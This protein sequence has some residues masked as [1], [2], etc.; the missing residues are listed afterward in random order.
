MAKIIPIHKK[1]GQLF[2]DSTENLI[3]LLN[4]LPVGVSYFDK[5]QRYQFNNKKYEEWI[6]I[7]LNEIQGKYIRDVLGEKTYES[8]RGHIEKA[9]SGEETIYDAEL[10]KKDGTTRFFQVNLIPHVDNSGN[11]EGCY[12]HVRDISESVQI[13][14]ERKE[15]KLFEEL[16]S[17]LSA[18]FIKLPANRIDQAINDALEE[19]G[20]F[21]HLDRSSLGNLTPDGREMVV[22][23]VWNRGTVPGVLKS[24]NIERHPW[25]LSPFLTGKD[26]VWSITEGLPKG[27]KEDVRLLEESGMQSFAGIPVKI[28][29]KLKACLGFSKTSE[30]VPFTHGIIERF[31][32]LAT[33]FGNVLARQNAVIKVEEI[34]ERLQTF[35][36]NSPVFMYLKD[37][38]GKHLFANQS[39]LKYF[40][41][42]LDEFIGTTAYDYLPDEVA[43][44]VEEQDRKVIEK[45]CSLEMDDYHVKFEAKVL[46]VK[47]IKFPIKLFEGESGV[48]GIVMDITSLKQKEEDLQ[49]AYDEIK[50]LKER[51]EVENIYLRDQI[52]VQSTHQD[53]IGKS[54][55]MQYVLY[56]IKQVAPSDTTVLILGETGTGKELVAEA[57]HTESSR[58][59]RH[60]VKVNCAALP[61]NL[62]ESELFGREKGA[63]TGSMAKQIGR[64]ELADKRTLFLDEIGELPL[65]LQAKLLRVIQSG[66]FERLGSPHTIR[67]D[68]RIIASTNRDLIDEVKNGRFREDLYYR[69]N[70]FPITVPPLHKRKEDIPMIVKYFLKKFGKKIG[71]QIERVP[72]DV[73]KSLQ[74]YHWPGNVRELE[75]IIER[76][77]IISPDSTLHL[78]DKLDISMTTNNETSQSKSLS[79]MERNHISRILDQTRWKI[80]GRNGA[81]EI[82]NLNPSTLRSRIRKLGI[83]KS[84]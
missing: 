39:L 80:E 69:L 45:G 64:F 79:D 31:H 84:V 24:Y 83:I 47:E 6:G 67:V 54:D 61:A 65:E 58:R 74:E 59:N 62:I 23:H 44:N 10:I 11:V 51:L 68:V 40:N 53:I 55:A 38:S 3:D 66:E 57:I 81:A 25:L 32:Y 70:V 4:S 36:Q 15:A 5:E 26:L 56:K 2:Q 29:G 43:R 75:N 12:A 77:M 1:A 41:V 48:G 19:V 18:N 28:E 50:V 34:V 52:F 27:S 7:S 21:L 8:I 35:M 63:F 9:L 60:L 76:S 13:N 33:V 20:T 46:H 16:V 78:A 73:I 14:D 17:R 72:Y 30:S 71:K 37:S 49:K 22:T 42:S 82:L